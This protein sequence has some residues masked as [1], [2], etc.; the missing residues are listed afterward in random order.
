[1]A[2]DHHRGCITLQLLLIIFLIFSNWNCRGI[3]AMRPLK[4][5]ERWMTKINLVIQ[6]LP[7]GP[8]PP[9]RGSPCTYIPGGKSRGRCA[10]ATNEGDSSDH[11]AAAPMIHFAAASESNGS[12]IQE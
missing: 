2:A 10:L 11:P 12:Q 4:E 5:G 7:R 1:M 8:V 6:S 3:V 9:S